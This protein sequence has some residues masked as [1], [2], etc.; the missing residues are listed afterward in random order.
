M[1]GPGWRGRELGISLF[2]GLAHVVADGVATGLRARGRQCEE[3]HDAIDHE[4]GHVTVSWQKWSIGRSHDTSHIPK[5]P[6][7]S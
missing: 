3:A 1:S 7:R 5:S 2:L 6:I 4:R